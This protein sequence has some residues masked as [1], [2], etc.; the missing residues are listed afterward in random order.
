MLVRNLRYSVSSIF[1]TGW[2]HP[3]KFKDMQGQ[4]SEDTVAWCASLTFKSRCTILRSRRCW[5]PSSISRTQPMATFS[6]KL[7]MTA[8]WSNSRPPAKSSTITT[9]FFGV[10]KQSMKLLKWGCLSFLSSWISS[11]TSSLP[12]IRFFTSFAAYSLPVVFSTHFFTTENRPL[13]RKTMLSAQNYG[14]QGNNLNTVNSVGLKLGMT[15][16]DHLTITGEQ[17]LPLKSM[18]RSLIK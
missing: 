5:T 1:A 8:R 9:K 13:K 17:K 10:S 7:S 12:T 11:S 16:I 6:V 4:F 2:M 3:V 15:R 18:Q 14:L